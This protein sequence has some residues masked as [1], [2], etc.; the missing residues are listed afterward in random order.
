MAPLG[1]GQAMDGGGGKVPSAASSME[2]NCPEAPQAR[3]LRLQ[4]ALTAN[5]ARPPAEPTRA[6]PEP[7]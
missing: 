4:L 5:D 3:N 6:K 1:D 7:A 2:R